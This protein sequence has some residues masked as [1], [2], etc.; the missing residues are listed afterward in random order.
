VRPSLMLS[1]R[2]L[3]RIVAAIAAAA[4]L[5]AA[6]AHAARAA[7]LGAILP[8]GDEA[9]RVGRA[10]LRLAPAMASPDHLA[11]ARELPAHLAALQ[12][13]D[14]LRGRTVR[15]EG[16]ILARTEAQ[17]CALTA[18]HAAKERPAV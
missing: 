12:R 2:F 5:P 3:L 14:F 4:V 15:L 6:R 7:A 18:L 11:A 10:Y 8:H 16:W 9:A 17:L 1:R 13:D